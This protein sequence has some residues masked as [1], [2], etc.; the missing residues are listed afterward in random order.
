MSGLDK[1]E[2]YRRIHFAV[3]VIEGCAKRLNI[4][5]QEMFKRLDGQD[6]IHSRLLRHYELLHTQSLEWVID[7]T[8]ETL[9][10]WEKERKE[11]VA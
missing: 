2:K 11:T 3:M 9:N 6:I 7:D 1:D 10:N 8:L 5:G 4:S